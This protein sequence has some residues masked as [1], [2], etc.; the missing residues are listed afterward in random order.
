M[1][2]FLC[3]IPTLK[4][5]ENQRFPEAP[6]HNASEKSSQ[7][8]TLFWAWQQLF[9]FANRP[10]L[11]LWLFTLAVY[12]M[13]DSLGS[14]MIKP[15]LV[16]MGVSLS[17]IAN[18]TL[19]GSLAGILAATLGGVIYYRLGPQACLLL[20]GL[21]QGFGLG[22]YALVDTTSSML[23]L[24]TLS[25]FEQSADGMATVALFA[26][27]MEHCRPNHEGTDYSLQACIQV[28]IAGIG[29]VLAGVIVN[30]SS[31]TH[32]FSSAML[33]TWICLIPVLLLFRKGSNVRP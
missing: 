33:L 5:D 8:I 23:M 9:S 21:M 4:F 19:I 26:M 31:Y 1:I 6:L 27:M 22:A 24:A 12:K 2:I 7:K 29:G 13:G 30:Q 15:L 14:A 3:L 32:L 17:S 25:I 18:L 11:P 16:D 10:G 20:F 28:S